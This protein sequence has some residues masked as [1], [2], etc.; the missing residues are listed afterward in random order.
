MMTDSNHKQSH[1]MDKIRCHWQSRVAHGNAH[2]VGGI[3]NVFFFKFPSVGIEMH[4][5]SL[6]MPVRK[7]VFSNEHGPAVG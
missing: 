5:V 3:L 6:V 1:F 2:S 7:Q 4:K